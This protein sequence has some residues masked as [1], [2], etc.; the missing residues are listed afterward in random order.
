MIGNEDLVPLLSGSED[1]FDR[2]QTLTPGS[3]V[4]GE[5]GGDEGDK[6]TEVWGDSVEWE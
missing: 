1:E 4:D 3:M 6:E 2:E 5:I